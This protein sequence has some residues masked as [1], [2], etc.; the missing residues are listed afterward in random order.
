MLKNNKGVT[1]TI[2][3]ISIIVMIII[4]GITLSS[5]DDLLRNSEKNRLKT[6]M[7]LIQSKAAT[8]LEDYLFDGT[9]NLGTT[10]ASDTQISGVGWIK[11]DNRYIY[12]EWD[13]T[14][15]ENYG[16][17]TENF[18]STEKF[19]IQYD[20]VDNEV[21]V[22]STSGFRDEDDTVKYTLSSLKN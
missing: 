20:K 15:L 16:I 12:R 17:D 22:A 21:D 19:I 3:V 6:N 13:K 2:L 1:L 18:S 7:Y 9:D 11:D 4:F 8:L 10:N 14:T 5:A